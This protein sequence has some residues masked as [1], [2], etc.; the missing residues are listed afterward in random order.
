MKK[1][2]V[3]KAFVLTLVDG[4]T[5]KFKAGIHEVEETIASHWYVLAHSRPVHEVEAAGTEVAEVAETVI[6]D[7]KKPIRKVKVQK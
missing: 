4:T 5:R 3:L 1:I 2:E 6:E 7:V